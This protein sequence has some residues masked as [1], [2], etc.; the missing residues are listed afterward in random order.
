MFEYP[1]H[2]SLS[3]TLLRY[4]IGHRERTFIF[5]TVTHART[6]ALPPLSLPLGFQMSDSRQNLFPPPPSGPSKKEK[7]ERI[8]DIDYR[9]RHEVTTLFLSVLCLSM[10]YARC[11]PRNRLENLPQIYDPI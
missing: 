10:R 6:M 4:W 3:K 7:K 2:S 8:E 1:L 9:A 11:A 5:G